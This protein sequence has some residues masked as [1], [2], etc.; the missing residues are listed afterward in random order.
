MNEDSINGMSGFGAQSSSAEILTHMMEQLGELLQTRP[1]NGGIVIN[2]YNSVG[3]RIDSVTTQN[4]SSD[5]WFG[6]LVRETSYRP[7]LP[8]ALNTNEARTLWNKA[9]QAG[10]IDENFQ[11]LISRTQSAL[12]ADELCERLGIKEKWKVFESLWGRNN[13]RGDYNDALNQR[14]SLEFRDKLKIVFSD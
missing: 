1:T 10:F 7:T 12:L 14:Q 11:P 4:F 5:K 6:Q 13:M 3:Q 2:Y 8:D 9:K